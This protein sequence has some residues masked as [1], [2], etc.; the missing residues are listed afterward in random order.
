MR[1]NGVFLAVALVAALLFS[2]GAAWAGCGSKSSPGALGWVEKKSEDASKSARM[3]FSDVEAAATEMNEAKQRGDH[4]DLLRQRA[5]KVMELSR[6]FEDLAGK[7]EA[8]LAQIEAKADTALSAAPAVN[9]RSRLAMYS[10]KV[11]AYKA[12]ASAI[13]GQ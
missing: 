3:L 4:D 6:S 7:V 13:L 8:E 5:R 9:A 11:R 1:R 2:V 10:E 12:Q